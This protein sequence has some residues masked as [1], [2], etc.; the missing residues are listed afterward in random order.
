MSARRAL[1]FAVFTALGA[2]LVFGLLRAHDDTAQADVRQQS[3]GA[4]RQLDSAAT[5]DYQPP[6]PLGPKERAGEI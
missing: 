6:A 2:V 3:A 5:N 1:D 4:E